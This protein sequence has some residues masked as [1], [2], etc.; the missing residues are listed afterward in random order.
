MIIDGMLTYTAG[1][2]NKI[3][4]IK[5]MDV[6]LQEMT[7]AQKRNLLAMGTIPARTARTNT[8]ASSPT[9]PVKTRVTTAGTSVPGSASGKLIMNTRVLD[10]GTG[11][12][13]RVQLTANRNAF[14]AVAYYREAGL[15]REA[16]VEQHE[17][18]YKYTVGPFSTYEQAVSYKNQVDGLSDI[19][20]AF[21]VAYRNGRR[22]STGSVR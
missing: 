17:G 12:Y 18:Y 1:N 19:N 22:I 6:Y 8:T 16:L 14:D 3:V 5:E 2:N 4:E 15:D 21:V 20:G 10:Y 7:S 11:A 13:Y 9:E